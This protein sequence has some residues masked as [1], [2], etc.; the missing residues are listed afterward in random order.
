MNRA[1]PTPAKRAA[2][3][4]ITKMNTFPALEGDDIDA[5]ILHYVNILRV[6]GIE[7]CQSCQGGPGHCYEEPTVDFLGD[8][9]AGPLAVGVALTYGLPVSE[10]RRV[11]RMYQGEMTDP[12]W[13]MTFKHNALEHLR[14]DAEKTAA[15]AALHA[16][17][18]TR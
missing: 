12:V 2:E 3:K 7:T 8:R 16:Q 14:L 15:Y 5:G 13:S 11:W 6:G 17:G 10:L 18:R 1:S 4:L 9:A